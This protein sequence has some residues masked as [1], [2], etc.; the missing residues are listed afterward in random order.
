MKKGGSGGERPSDEVCYGQQRLMM[1]GGVW[2]G[3]PLRG[4]GGSAAAKGTAAKGTTYTPA[5]P[6]LDQQE[7]RSRG[8][9]AAAKDMIP[10]RP[11][12]SQWEDR[13]RARRGECGEGHYPQKPITRPTRGG[14]GELHCPQQ[15]ATGSTGGGVAEPQRGHGGEGH[16][17]LIGGDISLQRGKRASQSCIF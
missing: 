14:C 13:G 4:C 7:G 3:T 8:V 12:P 11:S 2:G 16:C 17:P 9:A 10:S 15:P 5:S 1:K 6:A